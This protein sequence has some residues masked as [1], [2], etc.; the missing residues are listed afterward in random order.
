MVWRSAHRGIAITSGAEIKLSEGEPSLACPTRSGGRS[1]LCRAGRD[2]DRDGD[3]LRVLKAVGGPLLEVERADDRRIATFGLLEADGVLGFL[4]PVERHLQR[5]RDRH[6]LRASLGPSNLPVRSADGGAPA[7]REASRCGV[8][9]RRAQ[10]VLGPSYR[11]G[12]R[13]VGRLTA[14]SS[15]Q[16]EP[17]YPIPVYSC[18]VHRRQGP[19]L[20]VPLVY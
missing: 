18:T 3:R 13:H 10:D 4:R 12:A 9:T 5:F 17:C 8:G 19:R 14:K 16:A 7:T 6:L 20:I 11:A 15:P 2:L 1:A